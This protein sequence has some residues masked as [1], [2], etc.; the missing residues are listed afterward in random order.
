MKVMQSLFSIPF[1]YVV[2]SWSMKNNFFY[3][4]RNVCHV[5]EETLQRVWCKYLI[6]STRDGGIIYWQLDFNG[7]ARTGK[8]MHYDATTGHRLKTD[9]AVNWVHT[10]LKQT[11]V[12]PRDQ[13]ITQCLFGEHLLHSDDINGIVALVESEKSAILGTIAFPQYTWVAVGGKQNLTAERTV[14][15]CNRTVILF[16]DVDAYDEWKEASK[17]LFLCKRVIVSDLLEKRATAEERENKVDIGDWLIN[18][19]CGTH[20]KNEAAGNETDD[21]PP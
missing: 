5:S 7:E 15:L 6:G 8:I 1:K 10:K 2:N 14:A 16:P 9:F 21:H 3:F 4:L 19:M 12:I 20:G 13:L 18:D 11:G 17:K